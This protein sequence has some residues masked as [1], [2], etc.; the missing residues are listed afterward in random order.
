MELFNDILIQQGGYILYPL[1]VLS[2]IALLIFIERALFLH[3]GQINFQDFLSGIQNLIEKKRLVEALTLCEETPGPMARLMKSALLQYGTS[4]AQI[5]SA[6]ETAALV[7]I[8]ILERRIGSLA[9]IARIAP[10]LGFIGTLVAAFQ[11]LLNL[12]AANADSSLFVQSLAQAIISS[13]IGLSIAALAALAYHFLY[14]RVRAL[15]YDLERAGHAIQQLML[16]G[17]IES[18][19][20][21]DE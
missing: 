12:E 14:G 21:E 16:S 10:L 19:K 7:E 17:V 6:I 2:I 9:A 5:R 20:D 15:V 1:F 3:K 18:K 8:P 4:H 13:I 11:A